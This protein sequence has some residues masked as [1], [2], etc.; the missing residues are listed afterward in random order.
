MLNKYKNLRIASKLIIGFIIVALLAGAIGIIGIVNINTIGD[1]GDM[2][3]KDNT[4]GLR[5]SASAE[6]YY[7]RIRFNILKALISEGTNREDCI[8]KIDTYSVS[9]EENLKLFEEGLFNKEDQDLYDA[10]RPQYD[11]YM[12]LVDKLVDLIKSGKEDEARDLIMGELGSVGNAVQS[13]F[14]SIFEYNVASAQSKSENNQKVVA[15]SMTLMIA[16]AVVGIVIAILLGLAISRLISKP[17]IVMAD[18]AEKLSLGY[19][20]I[21]S[22]TAMVGK[23]EIGKL[24]AAFVK[25]AEGIKT[26]VLETQRMASGDLTVEL[27][28]RSDKDVLNKSL[29]E[30]VE[31]LNEL[32]VSIQNSAEQVASGSNLVSNS[33]MALSQG[34]TEQ[35]SS[36]EQLTASLEEIASQT[37][38]NAQ[39]AQSA[40][41]YA[42]NAKIDAE[43]GNFKMKDMLNAMEDIN[44]SSGSINKII[45]V[46]DDIA[47]QTNILALNAAVEA[48]RAGQHGKG[49][50]V[51]AEEVRTLA[52]KSA[53]AAK[54]TTDLIE[55]SIKKVEI[56]TRIASETAGAL[57]KIVEEVTRAAALIEEIAAASGEQAS[58]IEQVNQ[59][60]FMVSSVVQNNAATSEESAAASEE[61]SSQAAQLREVVSTFKVTNSV[62]APNQPPTKRQQ[63]VQKERHY[64]AAKASNAKSTNISLSN[65]D[66]GKY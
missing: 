49:F 35:A 47:F 45:K 6:M 48:A 43:N 12:L 62:A 65:G 36:V 30:L 37:T 3:F 59:G 13:S 2:L 31:N 42:K 14:D 55:G 16:V 38:L 27:A 11:S 40:N 9:A 63:A 7:Q 51:V 10:L 19:V 23:D 22:N 33:S 15:S 52:A 29:I 17:L 32:V 4:L 26:Q 24:T 25:M 1:A 5:Y 56:G 54:E 46:I 61:L 41:E 28:M 20:E 44:Q 18:D 60:V 66:F 8:V 39:N 21:H 53:Q 50:A 58:A 64:I 57:S 34:A